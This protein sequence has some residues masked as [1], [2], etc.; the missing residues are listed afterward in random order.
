LNAN[1]L[2]EFDLTDPS[3]GLAHLARIQMKVEQFMAANPINTTFIRREKAR[4]PYSVFKPHNAEVFFLKSIFQ[5]RPPVAFFPY[6][7]Y[8]KK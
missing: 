7:P 5:N 8:V 2:K 4:L 3:T 6:P 1:F